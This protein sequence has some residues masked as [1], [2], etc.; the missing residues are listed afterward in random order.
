MV[1]SQSLT[2]QETDCL[3]VSLTDRV[4]NRTDMQMCRWTD[5]G[6]YGP[7]IDHNNLMM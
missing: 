1:K 6:T 2:E 3:T 5:G 4:T 7:I